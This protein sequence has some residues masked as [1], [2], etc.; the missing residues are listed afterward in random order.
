MYS[1][2]YEDI[3]ISEGLSNKELLHFSGID[4]H[5]DA[6]ELFTKKLF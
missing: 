2:F 3:S 6:A 5:Q 4:K 1:K